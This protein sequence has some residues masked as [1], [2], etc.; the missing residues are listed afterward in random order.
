ME[1]KINQQAN[2][3]RN[4]ELI[5]AR[6]KMQGDQSH[7]LELIGQYLKVDWINNSGATTVDLTWHAL[8]DICGPVVLILGGVDRADDHEKL[9]Q[10]IKEKVQTVICLGSTPEKYFQAFR[11]SAKLIVH[12]S[13]MEEAI[14]FAATLTKSGIK[15]V[16][17]SPSCL[18]YDAFDNYKNRGNKFRELVKAYFTKGN[19]TT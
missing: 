7:H 3:T 2:V 17:F 10:L 19:Q 15:T 14:H 1:N 4:E 5:R 8:R 11:Y 12:A 18:S 9:N 6:V 13:D 16:L